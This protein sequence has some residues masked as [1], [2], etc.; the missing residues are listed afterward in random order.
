MDELGSILLDIEEITQK[1]QDNPLEFFRDKSICLFKACLE[2]YYPG[3]RNCLRS[4]LEDLRLEVT[5]C[6]DQSCCSG[7]FLQISLSK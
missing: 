4:L 5:T 7:T 3:I 1:H 2:Y 6:I